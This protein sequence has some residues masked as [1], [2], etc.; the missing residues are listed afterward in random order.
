MNNLSLGLISN[1]ELKKLGVWHSGR[2]QLPFLPGGQTL[3]SIAA[4]PINKEIKYTKA[5]VILGCDFLQEH[6]MT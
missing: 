2:K 4:L 6:L 5:I 3:D 1:V